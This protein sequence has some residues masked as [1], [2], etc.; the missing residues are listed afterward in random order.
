MLLILSH[1]KLMIQY[2]QTVGQLLLWFVNY[3]Y[4]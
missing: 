1:T 4:V 3:E 2:F